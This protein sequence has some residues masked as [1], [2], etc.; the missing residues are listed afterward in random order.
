MYNK[1]TKLAFLFHSYDETDGCN[2]KICIVDNADVVLESKRIRLLDEDKYKPY[3]KRNGTIDEDHF[4]TMARNGRT[5]L[6]IRSEE[7][8]LQQE[9]V[10]K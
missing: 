10:N 7:L 6:G 3:F 4:E 2:R 1:K 8:P 9:A 5:L